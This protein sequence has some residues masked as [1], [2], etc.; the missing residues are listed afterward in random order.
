MTKYKKEVRSFRVEL[1]AG[2]ITACLVATSLLFST[3]KSS[4]QQASNFEVRLGQ[5]VRITA[6][7]GYC[8]FPSLVRLPAGEIICNV[9]TSPDETNPEGRSAGSCFSQDGGATWGR[10][11]PLLG[12]S[13]QGAYTPT[14]LPD[15][16]V[17]V[18]GL[19]LIPDPPGQSK[20]FRTSLTIVSRDGLEIKK[21][22]DI[23]I[24][25]AQPAL[26]RPIQAF[27]GKPLVSKV[28]DQIAGVPWGSIVRGLNGDLLVPFYYMTERDPKY[29]RSVL[30]RSADG[31]KTWNEYSTIAALGFNLKPWPGMGREG[32]DETD[33]VWLRDKRLYAVFRTGWGFMG[34][35]WSSDDGKTWTPPRP[36]PFKGVDPRIRRL[37]DG[38]LACTYGRPSPVTIIFSVDGT[39]RKWTHVTPIFTGKSKCYTDFTEVRPG[40]LLV[41]YD[42][43]PYGDYPIPD[44][45]HTSADVIYGTFV[46]VHPK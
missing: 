26:M 27:A 43:T 8:W 38:A 10:R 32:G 45:D 4:G 11:H 18:M 30:L 17:W 21:R 19:D 1:P 20:Q 44:T 37:S 31:G 35:A 23:V 36:L 39:G 5:T 33:I 22:R 9:T 3:A 12:L 46:E 24:R 13:S 42:S 16:T 7:R 40:E 14:P 29:Y 6:S 15:G 34:E 41:V 25:L 2:L 28:N